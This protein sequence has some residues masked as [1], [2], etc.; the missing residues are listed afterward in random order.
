[1]RFNIP[2]GLPADGPSAGIAIAIALYSALSGT[3]PLPRAAATGEVTIHGEVRPV[4]GVREKLAA[5]FEA[6]AE[7]V[8]IPVGHDDAEFAAEPRAHAVG[9]L[10]EAFSLVFGE[11]VVAGMAEP[12]MAEQLPL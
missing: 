9:T 2:G 11:Q 5:A 10:R 7:L 8:L 3:P 12:A 4:G 6:G 1:M